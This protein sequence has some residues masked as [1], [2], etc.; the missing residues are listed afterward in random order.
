MCRC[1]PS[2]SPTSAY[3]Q[4]QAVQNPFQQPMMTGAMLGAQA[5]GQQPQLQAQPTGFLMPQQTAMPMG[6]T[7]P[8]GLQVQQQQPTFQPFLAPQQTGFLQPQMTGA[9]PFRQST[10]FPQATGMPFGG[11]NM[12][13][14][15]QQPQQQSTNPFP[16][17]SQSPPQNPMQNTSPFQPA[18]N[19]SPFQSSPLES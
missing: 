7:N 12:A 5:F 11:Q 4:Q 3:F 6:S 18:Q 10:L 15:P 9:N 14:P 17:Q 19:P 1:S 2:G 16:M 13:A 8:F